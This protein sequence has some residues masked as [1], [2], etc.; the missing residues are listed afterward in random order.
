MLQLVEALGEACNTRIILAD[1]SSSVQA[2]EANFKYQVLKHVFNVSKHV[3][4]I[5]RYSNNR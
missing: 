3:V 1:T 2:P 4:H 5:F